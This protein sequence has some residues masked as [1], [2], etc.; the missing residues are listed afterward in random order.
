[1]S[2][3]PLPIS[4]FDIGAN[5]THASFTDLDAIL[6]RA[7]E[8]GVDGIVVTGTQLA[9]AHDALA[10]ARRHRGRLWSTAGVHPHHAKDYDDNIDA[11]LRAL[12]KDDVV[13]AVGECGLDYNRDFSPRDQQRSAFERQLQ[14]AVDVKKPLF[15]HE[16]DA[17]DDFAAILKNVRD[18]VGDVVVHCFTG[19]R[20][21]VFA[22]LDLGCMIG[23]TGWVCDERRGQLLRE[24]VK[25]IPLDRLL[26]ETD[27]PYLLPH[28]VRPKPS[29]DQRR[30][31]PMYLP[32][33][34][35]AIAEQRGD[36]VEVLAAAT[37]ANARRF[38][39]L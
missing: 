2:R 29:P 23:I 24:L 14:I 17:A 7:A 12:L 38:F 11:G 33:V 20:D 8:H 22:W 32:Y 35:R 37:T 34:V 5:L 6:A 25:E 26:I 9:Q 36:D 13:V 18:S 1:M 39:R 3:E 21:A 28:G 30:N 10:L 19:S 31:E 27:A 15:L 4:L 16:R